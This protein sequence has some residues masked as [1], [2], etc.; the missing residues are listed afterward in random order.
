[1][2]ESIFWKYVFI[3]IGVLIFSLLI[4]TILLRFSKNLG[5]RN[6][7]DEII[8]WSETSKPSLGGISFYMLFLLCFV[9]YPMIFNQTVFYTKS[10]LGVLL[11]ATL[12]FV[13]GLADDAYNTRPLPKFLTQVLCGIVLIYNGVH[14]NLFESYILNYFLTLIWVVGLMNS[15]NMLD[16]MDAI[17]TSVGICILL[18][19][20][21]VLGIS[22]AY[23]SFYFFM[24][25]GTFFSLLGFL[26]YNWHPSKLFMGDSGSQFLGVVLAALSIVTLWNPVGEIV[27]PIA[28]SKYF[29]IPILTF[30]IPIADTTTVVIN[31]LLKKSSPFIGGK[32]HTTHHLSYLG[33]SDQQVA[34]V[35]IFLSLL[36]SS[37]AIYIV[38]YSKEW[39]H[40]QSIL[41]S[42]FGIIIILAL[43]LTTKINKSNQENKND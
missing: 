21:V 20:I 1:M 7:T 28:I 3:A 39:S 31:R 19:I 42:A 5:R 25:I 41:F 18:T 15:I 12:G 33:L 4:N 23:N 9:L 29:L 16:N 22:K 8:R 36:C 2:P 37:L 30:I 10:E 6:V 26:Y 14:I 27:K 17:T 32:D 34:L 43:Y 35:I 40:I 24:S 38:V 13:M 11:A